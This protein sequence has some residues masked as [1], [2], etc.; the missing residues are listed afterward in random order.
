MRDGRLVAQFGLFFKLDVP[1]P[2]VESVEVRLN[3]W[4]LVWLKANPGDAYRDMMAGRANMVWGKGSHVV[5]TLN[6]PRPYFFGLYFYRQLLF[7]LDASEEF[8]AS[9][10]SMAGA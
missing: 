1:L 5:I 6:P 8:A 4:R 2:E 10:R 7:G 3:D 9:F